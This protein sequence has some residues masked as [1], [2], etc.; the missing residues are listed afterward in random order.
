MTLPRKAPRIVPLAPSQEV[1]N[2][3]DIAASAL[4]MTCVVEMLS[5]RS[6]GSS[7]I[8]DRLDQ[9][10]QHA[11]TGLRRPE[12][13]GPSGA[14]WAPARAG[15]PGAEPPA[16]AAPRECRTRRRGRPPRPSRLHRRR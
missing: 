3:T 9:E 5:L 7:L 15:R 12:R 10:D 4:A 14:A 16:R 13:A 6:S 1:R 8:A 2:A 11:L